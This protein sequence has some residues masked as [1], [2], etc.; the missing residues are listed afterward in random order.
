MLE[1][2]KQHGGIFGH[3][4]NDFVNTT[5]WLYRKMIKLLELHSKISIADKNIGENIHS[6][7]NAI[8]R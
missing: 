3:V 7:K 1:S 4:I 8:T 6:L 2:D 5:G